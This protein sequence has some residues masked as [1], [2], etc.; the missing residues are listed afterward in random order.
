M[1]GRRFYI[2]CNP[3]AQV[4]QK[5]MIYRRTNH[6]IIAQTRQR[7][8]LLEM[9]AELGF[10]RY[11]PSTYAALTQKFVNPKC[12][13]I[14]FSTGNITNMGSRTYYGALYALFYLK[15]TLGLKYVNIRLTNIVVN[16]HAGR[17]IDPMAFFERNR[18][19]CTCDPGIFPCCTYNPPGTRLKA[20]IFASGNVVLTGLRRTEDIE[21][22]IRD[23]M[24][25]MQDSH[26]AAS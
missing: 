9:L 13:N 2:Y 23:V 12:T 10:G 15:R 20:N 17:R 6:V 21:A 7:R 11:K 14:L 25:L 24:A 1:H 22:A 18:A 16:F 8:D 19:H 4:N 3:V 5:H 26:T